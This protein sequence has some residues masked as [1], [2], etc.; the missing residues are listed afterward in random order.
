MISAP[1]LPLSSLAAA[2][3]QPLVLEA[4]T[5]NLGGRRLLG[6]LH[7]RIAPGE[8]LSVMG[9]SGCGKSTLLNFLAGTLPAAFTA[10]GRAWVGGTD[11]TDLPTERRGAGI[12]FQDDLLF[13]HLSVGGNLAFALPAAVRPASARRA[14]IDAALAECGLQGFARRDP[15]TLSGGQRARVALM[16]T[17]LAAPRVLLLDEPFSQLDAHL[18]SAFRQWVFGH[19]RRHGLPTLLVTH[20]RADAEAA[21]GRVIELQA[22]A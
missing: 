20:D 13:P 16:R 12:L 8:C 1:V 18:R 11:L 7:A 21:G 9:P 3:T 19:A 14:R 10:S 2:A 15:T 22:P 5:L 17:L 4:V 6:P